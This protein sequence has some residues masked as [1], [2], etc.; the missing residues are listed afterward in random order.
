MKTS[1]SSPAKSAV[2]GGST[3]KLPLGCHVIIFAVVFIWAGVSAIW[4]HFTEPRDSAL[5]DTHSTFQKSDEFTS[6]R[7]QQL[8]HAGQTL[9]ENI[10]AAKERISRLEREEIERA[11]R[12][13]QAATKDLRAIGQAYPQTPEIGQRS[14]QARQQIGEIELQYQ[15]KYDAIRDKYEA[16]LR[17]QQDE[18]EQ[19]YQS[20]IAEINSGVKT[21]SPKPETLRVV[22]VSQ[23]NPPLNSFLEPPQNA[24][25]PDA[26]YSVVGIARD[27]T[28]NVRSGPSANHEI[29]ARLPNGSSQLRI[30]AA[31]VMNGTTEWVQITFGN[32]TGWVAK[33]YLRPET[34]NPQR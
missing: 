32:L 30:V 29:V 1:A 31:P 12:E 8:L 5:D 7:K 9:E 33:L 13:E 19:A 17:H 21:I 2:G 15:F 16:A 18:L 20:E 27:D 10:K 6:A 11:K 25:Q 26:L 23:S 4:D 24:S 28:L 14:Y 3:S 34:P 22:A